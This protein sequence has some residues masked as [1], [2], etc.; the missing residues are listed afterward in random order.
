MRLDADHL[1]FMTK[2][3]FRVLT[4]IEMGMKN[5]ELVPLP[6]IESI[7]ARLH[8]SHFFL[9]HATSRHRLGSFLCLLL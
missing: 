8:I 6:L 5:H 1:R 2:D 9:T 3:E 4:A 7:G